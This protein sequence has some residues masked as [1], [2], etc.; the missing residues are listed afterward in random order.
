MKRHALVGVGLVA[1]AAGA[2]L[3]AGCMGGDPNQNAVLI[4]EVA[5]TCVDA[6]ASSGGSSGGG[7]SSGSSGGVSPDGA[8]PA[9]PGCPLATFDSDAGGVEGFVLNKFHDTA[10]VNLGDPTL[11]LAMPPTLAWDGTQ[12]NPAPGSLTIFAPFEGAMMKGAN[13][14]V[15]FQTPNQFGTM[16]PQDWSKGT[17]HVRVKADSMYGGGVQPYVDT[18]SSYAFAGSYTNWSSGVPEGNGWLDFSLDLSAPVYQASGYDPTKVIVYGA[19]LSSGSA[20]ANQMP[21]TF[22][23]DSFYITGLDTCPTPAGVV[24]DA[25]ASPEGGASSDAGGGDGAAAPDGQGSGDGQSAE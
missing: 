18:T 2:A 16:H 9:L 20:G 7:T 12:G 24:S 17:L 6:G 3:A 25:G 21:V 11:M 1:A 15:D 23:V 4:C 13:N 19:Q 5:G 22:H 10:S 8:V 14:Y